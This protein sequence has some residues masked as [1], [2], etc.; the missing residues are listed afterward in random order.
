MYSLDGGVDC[1][2]QTIATAKSAVNVVT[3]R[4]RKLIVKSWTHAFYRDRVRLP[5]YLETVTREQLY[6]GTKPH[7][8]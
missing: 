2:L 5:I 7:Y 3:L 4:L 8:W 1:P 6:Q